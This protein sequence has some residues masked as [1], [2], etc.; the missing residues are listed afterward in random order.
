M[1]YAGG[2]KAA[3]SSAEERAECRRSWVRGVWEKKRGA[4]GVADWG[5][6]VEFG[7]W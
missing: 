5:S 4:E 7:V 3:K 6:M 2:A 1:R